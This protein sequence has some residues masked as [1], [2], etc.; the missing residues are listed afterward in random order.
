[1]AAFHEQSV[2]DGLDTPPNHKRETFQEVTIGMNCLIWTSTAGGIQG[3]GQSERE[4]CARLKLVR[5]GLCPKLSEAQAHPDGG[6][7]TLG[8]TAEG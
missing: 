7:S 1:M 8:T 3:C 5:R 2:D 4:G 6:Y